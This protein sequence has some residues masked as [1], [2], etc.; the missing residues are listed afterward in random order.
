MPKGEHLKSNH[1]IKTGD[2]ARD[3]TEVSV[4]TTGKA[5][6]H[7]EDPGIEIIPESMMLSKAEQEKLMNEPCEI[8]IEA[9]D[10]PNA[11]LF[12]HSGHNG[13]TQYVKR[14]E[15]QVIKLRYL[16]SLLAAQAT[17]FS[18][19]FG[20]TPD[21]QE[22]NRLAGRTNTTHRIFVGKASPA[23]MKIIK[24]AMSQQALA[25]Q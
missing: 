22:F 1:Q 20:R 25:A 12:V 24:E 10:D 17:K 21:G 14:G 7:I 9:D 15:T 16:Y 6:V 4:S 3:D 5:E 8:M 2:V 11:P 23:A 19:S 13:V 18:C